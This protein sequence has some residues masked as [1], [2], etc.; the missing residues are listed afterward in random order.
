[1]YSVQPVVEEHVVI[2]EEAYSVDS[3]FCHIA[4]SNQPFETQDGRGM[5][6]RA[7]VDGT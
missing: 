6:D 2:M 7:V 4:T 3:L 5:R 1:M